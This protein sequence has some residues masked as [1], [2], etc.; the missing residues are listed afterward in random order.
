[1]F[2]KKQIKPLFPVLDIFLERNNTETIPNEIFT[3]FLPLWIAVF[4]AKSMNFEE[5]F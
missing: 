5:H 3:A 2:F 4:K 1:M